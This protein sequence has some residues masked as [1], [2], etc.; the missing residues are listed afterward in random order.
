MPDWKAAGIELNLWEH[1]N[2]FSGNYL[3]RE[4]LEV[5]F[6]YLEPDENWYQINS[7]QESDNNYEWKETEDGHKICYLN[8]EQLI[9][10][11]KKIAG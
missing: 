9:D 3:T 6:G 10:E 7:V 4:V 1:P 11:C 2:M 8:G 5:A